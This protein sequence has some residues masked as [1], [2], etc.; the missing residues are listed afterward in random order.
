MID[1]DAI[2]RYAREQHRNQTMISSGKSS[3]IKDIARALKI[4]IG[5]VDRALHGRPGVSEK[6]KARVLKMAEQLGYKPNLAAQALK[7]NRRLS[8]AAILP[9]HI[10]HFF[11]PLRAG[12]R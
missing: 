12:I 2:N 3:G 11:D 4:S 10:S 7:L 1:P 8:I 6:T 5:T 9:R